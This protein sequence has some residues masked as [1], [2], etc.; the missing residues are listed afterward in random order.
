[1]N[2]QICPWCQ[3]EIVWDEELGPESTCPHCY[4]ELGEYRT[5]SIPIKR[6][7]K[8]DIFE[9]DETNDEWHAYSNGVQELLDRQEEVPECPICQEYLVLAGRLTVTER[10][11]APN[12]PFPGALPFLKPPYRTDVFVCSHCFTFQYRLSE[13]DRMRT[14]R[15]IAGH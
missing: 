5:M 2:Q 7:E 3:S 15:T 11:F 13:E 9:E 10:E 12:V 6:G 14:I 8:P 4:N 1:M